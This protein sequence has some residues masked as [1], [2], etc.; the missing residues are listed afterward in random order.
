[1]F[2]IFIKIFKK[3]FHISPHK[4]LLNCKI[5]KAK[6]LLSQ[7][8]DTIEVAYTVG[9][10]DQSHFANVFKRYVAATPNEY[11]NNTKVFY[12]SLLK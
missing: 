9:F 6:E 2:P 7:G 4:Y 10:Y 12:Q 1:M 5:N 8:M 11:K 3:Q